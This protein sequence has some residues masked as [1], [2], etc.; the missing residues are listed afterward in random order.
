MAVKNLAHYPVSAKLP[1]K[2]KSCFS[3]V[4]PVQN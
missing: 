3:L 2:C 1:L 4:F